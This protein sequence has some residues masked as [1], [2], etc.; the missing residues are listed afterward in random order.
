MLR[1]ASST[2]GPI[3][4]TVGGSAASQTV[5]A[6]N[7]GDGSLSLTTTVSSS[8][9]WLTAS[10]GSSRPCLSTT[11][12]ASCIP[13]QFSLSTAGLSAGTYTG[14][15]TVGASSST[16]DA[17]QTIT[18]TVRVGP[19]D[20]YAAPGKTADLTITTNHQVTTSATTQDGGTWLSL[21]LDGTGSFRFVYPYRIHLSPSADM[22]P[23]TYTGSV[24]TSGSST[25][26]EN[27]TIPVTMHL[28]TQPIAQPNPTQIVLHLAQG[29][30]PLVYPFDPVITL[31]NMGM[32]TLTT[33]GLNV[34]G[35]SWIKA[36]PV[37]PG[38]VAIDPTGLST[39]DNSAT[40]TLSSNAANGPT[41]VP[42]SLQIVPKGSPLIYYQGAVDNITQAPGDPISPG[43]WA[44]V[45]GEQFSFVDPVINSTNPPLATTM[46]GAS[47]LVNGTA[48]P[49]YYSSVGQIAFQMPIDVPAGTAQVQVKRDDGQVNNIVTV[50][51]VPRAPRLLP[52][53]YNSDFTINSASNPATR[54][55]IIYFFGFGFGATDPAVPAGAAA[56]SSPLAVI[57]EQMTVN[58]GDSLFGGIAIPD[59]KGLVATLP[60]VYQVNVHIPDLSPT[61]TVQTSVAFQNARSNPIPI[62]IQ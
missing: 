33:S 29:T 60:G 7:A 47:V 19:V 41:T 38:Y 31:S 50:G 25:A 36:D 35:G 55:D 52:T 22:P 26:S 27:L 12:A 10:V 6:Y 18:V 15:V 8:A 61:G 42:V 2:V 14:I 5:E 54:G 49:L 45:K 37:V 40:V 62:Y 16:I 57:N 53:V 23:G 13:L 32:G 11:D 24:T 46:G 58:F 1:L 30:K 48:A 56:P 9:P 39:G 44:V 34:S 17:P 43:D 59:F 20:I 28:T 21:V 51:V 3:P 4:V